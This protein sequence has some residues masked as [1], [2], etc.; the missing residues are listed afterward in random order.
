MRYQAGR[1]H[2]VASLALSVILAACSSG[3]GR[4][5]TSSTSVAAPET[6]TTTAAPIATTAPSTPVATTTMPSAREVV[7]PDN[8]G[9]DYQYI[10]DEIQG[11]IDRMSIDPHVDLLDLI[12]DPECNCYQYWVNYLT[13]LESNNWRYTGDAFPVTESLIVL[14]VEEGVVELSVTQAGAAD[15]VV[16]EAGNIIREEDPWR[17]TSRVAL[18]QDAEGRWRVSNVVG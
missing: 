13:E 11:F 4:A 10:W 14:T 1:G 3:D 2:I 17:Y 9:D 16:D 7:L 8:F 15:A 12:I 6:S 18:T 5:P